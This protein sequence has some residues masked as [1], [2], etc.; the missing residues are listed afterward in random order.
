MS[1]LILTLRID[2]LFLQ[3]LTY[4]PRFSAKELEHYRHVRQTFEGVSNPLKDRPTEKALSPPTRLP[5]PVTATPP[6]PTR[7]KYKSRSSTARPKTPVHGKGKGKAFQWDSSSND[8]DDGGQDRDGDDDD[9]DDDEAYTTSNDFG[10]TPE[11]EVNGSH[12]G[13]GVRVD[14]FGDAA[15]GDDEDIYGL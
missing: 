2:L 8:E 13:K 11:R 9:D 5:I 6:L 14:G 4:F 7:P 1:S 12:R 15:E 10:P 3:L